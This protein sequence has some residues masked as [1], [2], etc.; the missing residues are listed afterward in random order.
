MHVFCTAAMTGVIW[1]VQLVVY[2][3]FLRVGAE[4]FPSYHAAHMRKITWVVGPLML[5]E[6]ATLA[7]LLLR[8]T[9]SALSIVAATALGIAWLSTAL[10]QVPQHTLLGQ[11]GKSAGG[12]LR[13]VR[14][15]WIRTACWTLRS[16]I[17]FGQG[18]A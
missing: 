12:I 10:L 16:L 9:P 4:D 18:L 8:G 17:L 11:E 1:V 6:V 13:L 14:G 2:P 5:A 7:L 15:N 3:A